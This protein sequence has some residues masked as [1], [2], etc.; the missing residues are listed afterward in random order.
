[1]HVDFKGDKDVILAA[2]LQNKYGHDIH[3]HVYIDTNKLA[4]IHICRGS[5]QF[6]SDKLKADPVFMQ[7]AMSISP[8][9]FDFVKGNSAF[10][11]D[12]DAE[13]TKGDSVYY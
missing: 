8:D 4:N 7:E 3:R 13:G 5:I 10:D 2:M 9:A 6:A 11:F 12:I 1:V